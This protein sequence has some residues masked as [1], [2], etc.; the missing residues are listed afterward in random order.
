MAPGIVLVQPQ[1]T[2]SVLDGI[3]INQFQ[4][5]AQSATGMVFHQHGQVDTTANIPV[6]VQEAPGI[7][8]EPPSDFNAGAMFDQARGTLQAGESTTAQSLLELIILGGTALEAQ[9]AHVD[10]ARIGQS[11][12]T[13]A[14]R[15][16]AWQNWN[17]VAETNIYAAQEIFRL[18][19]N[20]SEFFLPAVRRRDLLQQLSVS[21]SLLAQLSKYELMLELDQED[22]GRAIDEFQLG[23]STENA[24]AG[25]AY[26]LLG[27]AVSAFEVYTQ[28]INKIERLTIENANILT[29]PFLSILDRPEL[30][31]DEAR[32]DA[33]ALVDLAE[34]AGSG[35]AIALNALNETDPQVQLSKLLDA[36]TA[37][38]DPA[39]L[40]RLRN[41]IGECNVD[42]ITFVNCTQVNIAFITNRNQHRNGF[43]TATGDGYSAGFA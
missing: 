8:I 30:F 29:G 33:M 19:A 28:A 41:K 43:G 4:A 10:L 40:G 16:M 3:S 20:S 11:K 35:T 5:P 25:D 34:V 14:G 22:W 13:V 24:L 17:A 21:D 27:E 26:R 2:G 32:A 12:G 37:G 23:G 6:M 18:E 36:S 15:E 42:G 38:A 1:I 9:V 39:V 31:T 7:Q